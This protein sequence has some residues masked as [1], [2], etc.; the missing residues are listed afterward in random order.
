MAPVVNELTVDAILQHLLSETPKEVKQLVNGMSNYVFEATMK[1]GQS[2]I[3]RINDI[4]GKIHQFQKEQWCSSKV[5]ERG[6]P[7]V[8]ILEVG[9]EIVPFPYMVVRKAEG[10]EANKYTGD[11]QPILAEMA[12]YTSIINK[13]PTTGIGHSF[14]WSQNQISKNETW[15]DY[16]DK[17]MRVEERMQIFEEHAIFNTRNM[18]K[19]RKNV[20]DMYKW[21][22]TPTLN[23]GDMRLKNILVNEKGKITAILDWENA[24]SN[25]APIWDLSISLHDLNSDEKFFFIDGYGLEPKEYEELTPAIKTVNLLNYA[26]EIRF[27]AEQRAEPIIERIRVKLNGGLDL[28]SL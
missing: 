8:E 12:W 2:F 17:E 27:Q 16:L 11:V 23:H 9:N 14:D 7:A 13:V 5:R 19:L 25:R 1:D 18:Q 28:F 20:D 4:P 15:R 3:V 24:V 21:E 10:I 26:P 22:F 6:V